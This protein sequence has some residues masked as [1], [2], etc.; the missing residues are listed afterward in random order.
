M[1]KLSAIAL[2][3]LLPCAAQADSWRLL[4]PAEAERLTRETPPS[5]NCRPMPDIQGYQAWE[6]FPESESSRWSGGTEISLETV[7]DYLPPVVQESA[8][9]YM[10]RKRS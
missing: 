3:C 10:K 5:H 6:C 4:S 9:R 7:A 2:L 8:L 1:T